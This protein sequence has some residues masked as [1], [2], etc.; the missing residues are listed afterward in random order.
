MSESKALTAAQVK[1]VIEQGA[2]DFDGPSGYEGVDQDCITIPFLKI[3]QAS[4]DEAKKG[5]PARIEGLDVGMFFCPTTRKVYGESVQPVIV[6]FYRQYV[7]YESREP[8]A[9]FLGTM[10]AEQFRSAIEP[11]ATRER[12]YHLDSE[13]HRYV[14][15]RNFIVY[16]HGHYEDGPM[17]MSMSSTGIKPSQKWLTLA[18]NVRDDQGR[19]APIWANVWEL[20]TAYQDNPQG[21]Y[22]QVTKI[23]RK[24]WIPGNRKAM[25]VAAFLDANS[26]GSAD[27]A[28]SHAKEAE[29]TVQGTHTVAREAAEAEASEQD[30][31]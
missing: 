16:L 9:K 31:F 14:D 15:T 26:M 2:M 18:Q 11:Y 17:L 19:L 5:N 10:T 3:A 27:L 21:S 24:G 6:R 23:E 4:T 1:D 12:S 8:D 29:R 28:A 7:I 30:M 13:G 22:Y 25:L 20:E